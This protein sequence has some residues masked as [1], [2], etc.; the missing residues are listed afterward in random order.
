MTSS[1]TRRIWLNADD[2]GIGPGVN[3][4]IRDL[5]ARR[6]INA[7]SVMVVANAF[8]RAEAT[9]LADAATQGKGF[10]GLHL[11]LTAP[12]HPLTLHFR[13]LRDNA[14][15]PQNEMLMAGFL[16]RL[17]ADIVRAEVEAQIGAFRDA[18]GRVPAFVDGHLHCQLYPVVR[19]AVVAA[20]KSHAPS[21]WVRQCRRLGPLSQRLTGPKALFLDWLS[22]GFERRAREAGLAVNPGFSGAYDFSRSENFAALFDSF[23][24]GLPD[25]GVI[26]CH[27]GTVDD[28]LRQCDNLLTPR[29][30][31]YAY[32]GGD[33]FPQRLTAANVTLL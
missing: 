8:S 33:V 19:D 17:D 30:H 32:L 26:M 11:V 2:Y 20:V 24:D 3:S 14:F 12:F 9:A 27:P 23:L 10:I 21:A 18:F 22:T 5:I 13:P 6:R 16:R 29:E 7:T 25:G 15:L 31:E 4:A 28:V 1:A